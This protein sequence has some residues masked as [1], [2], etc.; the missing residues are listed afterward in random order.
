MKTTILGMGIMGRGFAQRLHALGFDVCAWN[1]TPDALK[2]LREAG[3]HCEEDLR[4]AVSGA[5]VVL[6]ILAHGPAVDAVKE[7]IPSGVCWLQMSTVG[8]EWAEKFASYA[9]S[10]KISWFDAP[11]LGSRVPA[12]NGK[13]CILCSTEASEQDRQKTR[14]ILEAL[15]Q[16]I[17]DLN[18][19]SRASLLKLCINN[20]M[21]GLLAGLSESLRLAES[22]QISHQE[23]Y[24]AMSGAAFT[25]PYSAQK[26]SAMGEQNFDAHFPLRLALKDLRLV[27]EAALAQSLSMPASDAVR[28]LL[29]EVDAAGFGDEDVAAIYR[30][31]QHD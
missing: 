22:Y 11:V 25:S 3:L 19:N 5:D 21:C 30:A 18:G 31:G 6:T 23:F 16:K 27:H 4:K 8:P 24:E 1:R 29:E 26:A 13:L 17:V 10:R 7:A 14:P 28:A 20:W 2:P 12:A 9:A 15:S